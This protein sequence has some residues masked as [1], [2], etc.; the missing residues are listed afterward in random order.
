MYFAI[1]KELEIKKTLV[2]S[3][4]IHRVRLEHG[5]FEFGAYRITETKVDFL[6]INMVN[7]TPNFK[8]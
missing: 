6:A 5:K 7:N 4:E 2:D 1:Q 3:V 8:P